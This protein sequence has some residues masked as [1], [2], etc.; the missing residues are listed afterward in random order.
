MTALT[1]FFVDRWQLTLVLFALLVALGASAV[2]NIAKS[3]DPVTRFPAVGVV[4]VLPGADAEQVERLIAIPV[5][6][7]LN[8]LDDVRQITSASRA[9]VAT[10]GIEFI[11]G[12]DPEKKYDEVVREL[13]VVR[14]TLPNGV[15]LVRADRRNPAQANVVQLALVSSTASYRQ[16][17]AYARGLR[18]A[19]ERAPGVQHAEVWGVPAAEVRVAADLDKLAAYR[20]PLTAVADALAREG[21]DAPIGAVESGG[22][23]FNVEAAGSFENL[24]Q[25]RS[26]VLRARDG[27]VVTVGD[28]ADVAWANDEL[29][30][31]TRFDGERALFV[32]ARAKLGVTVFDVIDG[33]RAQV[34]GFAPRLPPEIRLERG[35]DQAETVEHRLGSLARDFMLA[36]ALVLLTLLP[37]GYRASLVV[38]MSIPLSLAM[39]V[40]ALQFFGFSLNQLSI[41]G[42]VLALGLLVDDSIVVTE[43]IARRLRE[44]LSPRDAAIAGVAE[45]N[46][47]VIGCTATLLLA[48][49]PLMS[50]PE[51]AG[52][53]IRSLPV[54]VVCTIASSLVVSLTIVPF[55]ASRML[56]RSGHANAVLDVVMGAI[57]RVYRPALRV[58]LGW[59]KAT[60]VA[61]LALFGASLLLVPRLGFSLFPENDSP[62]FLIDVELPQ[63]SAVSETDRAVLYADRL[64]AQ[65]PQ[66]VWRFANTGRGNPQI[67]YNVIPEEQQSNVGSIYTRFAHW[68]PKSGHATLEALRTKLN[69][70][71]GARFNV[72]RFENGPPI[73]APIAVRIRGPDIEALAQIAGDVER[74]VRATPG[75][76]DVTN[77]LA[78]RLVDL[79]MNIDDAAV[80][81]RGVPAGAVDQ[82]LRIA[83]G[84]ATVAAFRDPIGDSYPIVLRAPRSD[85]MTVADLDRL[86]V[87]NDRGAATPIADLARP[88]LKSGPARIDR[89]E[90]E[91]TVTIRAYTQFGRLTSAVTRA[92]AQRL[93]SVRLPAG[94]SL[95]F[96]GAAEAQQRSFG[97][98]LPA[99]LVALFGIMAVL[100]LEFRSFSTTAVVA[101][102]VPFGIMGGLIALA[103]AGESLSF[104]AVIGFVAL[105]GIEI[106]NSILL[107]EFANQQRARGV[108]LREAIERA[109]EIRFLPVL[110]TSA[111]AIGGLAPLVFERSPLYSPLAMVLIGGLVSST[112][113]ARIV[114][115]AMYLLLARAA[116]PAP[117]DA[118]RWSA[119]GGAAE[120]PR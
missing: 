64:L 48:F 84:G 33:I 103:L 54:A 20:L 91:R 23:R 87:W 119:N 117:V 1:R 36:I 50:L 55:L 30:H 35:F 115:P 79:D 37:L 98:L 95:S 56:G 44:G 71:P 77:P 92:V 100:L 81:L 96:G 27:S 118:E 8:G 49:V 82:T 26:V 46:V 47:A 3:E 19:I 68:E 60:V 32:T 108:E 15:T 43:N 40:V 7:A 53:F 111:T 18:D 57:H 59:P 109:G 4:V 80:N 116:P 16:M 88:Q 86:Y 6:N 120:L 13:N 69:E 105:V 28:V 70:Y 45:I 66:F 52:D 58:A 14:P 102:V 85:V 63:G 78:A 72:R 73:E 51:G 93:E 17:E 101:F 41:A 5:E 65:D 113:I 99:V 34:D 94:Y 114:T 89:F 11:Y 38:M 74:I 42:F 39:G 10:I 24:D 97:G 62:Y 21:L 104:T 31:I 29:R 106:K 90:R 12:S 76:R 110:L 61:G 75:T 22:R 9:G 107:V 2:K 83:I 67:Y 25:I 112:L